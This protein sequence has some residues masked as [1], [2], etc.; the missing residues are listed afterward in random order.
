MLRFRLDKFVEEHFESGKPIVEGI[1]YGGENVLLVAPKKSAKTILSLQ[2]AIAAA[3]GSTLAGRWRVP[4]AHAVTYVAMEGSPAALQVA[5]VRRLLRH[6]QLP[7]PVT[8]ELVITPHLLLDTADGYADLKAIV[9]ATRPDLLVL[10]PMYKLVSGSLKDDERV[11][12]MTNRLAELTASNGH[13][14]LIDHHE[15]RPKRDEWGMAVSEGDE[16]YFGSYKI[17]A[18]V[19]RSLTMHFNK[20]QHRAVLSAGFERIP[21]FGDD[22][23]TLA[24]HDVPEALGF[25]LAGSELL[26][27]LLGEFEGKGLSEIGKKLGLHHEQVR[28]EIKKLQEEGVPLALIGGKLRRVND[29]VRED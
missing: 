26:R 29:G 22:P 3:A 16:A 23:V 21:V 9:A 12:I 25:D 11:G 18:W 5:Y 10:D 27:G 13:A 19:D 6:M 17:G 2:I 24:L 4:R 7:A 15:H 8:M 20:K 28:R 1:I 14:T